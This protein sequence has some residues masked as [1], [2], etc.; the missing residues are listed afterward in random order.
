MPQAKIL[1]FLFP[2]RFGLGSL[3]PQQP[4]DLRPNA[5]IAEQQVLSMCLDSGRIHADHLQLSRRVKKSLI[6]EIWSAYLEERAQ[7]EYAVVPPG[8][9]LVARPPDVYV[10][11]K[12]K[13]SSDNMDYAM[14]AAKDD[15]VRIMRMFLRT[16]AAV[17]FEKA[18]R[19]ERG[20]QELGMRR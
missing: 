17:C 11:R 1:L 2:S 3:G 10:K 13:A 7:W 15:M 6:V 14:S 4:L 8:M 5:E 12:A 9:Q 16:S 19:P 18:E 20:C